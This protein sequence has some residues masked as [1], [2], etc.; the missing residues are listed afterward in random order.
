MVLKTTDGQKEL[1]SVYWIQ[2]AGL[3]T[4]VQEENDETS[5]RET[6]KPLP[7]YLFY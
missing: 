2:S 1:L 5:L 7:F 6:K 3:C 4:T